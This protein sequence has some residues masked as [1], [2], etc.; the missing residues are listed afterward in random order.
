M[1]LRELTFNGNERSASSNNTDH[2]PPDQLYASSKPSNRS[3]M[4]LCHLVPA[5][6]EIML[7]LERSLRQSQIK[8]RQG[9]RKWTMGSGMLR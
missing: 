3:T 8:R 9:S 2:L 5:R 1:T 4:R 7:G 6:S